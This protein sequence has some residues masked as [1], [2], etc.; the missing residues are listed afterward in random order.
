MNVLVRDFVSDDIEVYQKF[1][2]KNRKYFFY[3]SVDYCKFI[4]DFLSGELSI[5]LAYDDKGQLCGTFPV[6]CKHGKY[7]M[8]ANS[9]PYF[10]AN[11]GI[12]I[13]SDLNYDD[14]VEVWR[15]LFAYLQ[16][17]EQKNNIAATVIIN[18]PGDIYNPLYEK[19]D[20]DYVEERFSLIKKLQFP[21]PN[22][23][24]DL[25]SE[26]LLASYHMAIRRAVRKTL[27]NN[28]KV[29]DATPDDSA[30][31]FLYSVHTANMLAVGALPK[32]E[33]FFKELRNSN[34]EYKLYSA[35]YEE[36]KVAA[37]LLIYYGDYVEYY[38]PAIVEEYRSLQALSC[39][40]HTAMTDAVCDG[41]RWWNWGGT[42]KT[43]MDGVYTFKSRW[44]C[45]ELEYK[46]FINLYNK[47]ILKLSAAEL[48]QQYENF[49]VVPFSQLLKN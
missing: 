25:I 40:I 24:K 17:W 11:G 29:I 5:F 42:H 32:K 47:D 16:N 48:S 28:I 37:L 12:T 1:L 30:W 31:N 39:I 23:T 3:H 4:A 7:G 8:V 26:Q 41:R 49:F 43:G 36:K 6:I 35:I 14:G 18:T 10:G 33:Q 19:F 44:G 13:D 9:L 34:L 15:A 20:F 27:R 38:T 46:Y 21:Q 2:Q 22:P 45:D